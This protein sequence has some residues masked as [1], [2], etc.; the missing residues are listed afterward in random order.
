MKTPPVA[1]L[2]ALVVLAATAGPA[3][4]ETVYITN[5]LRVGLHEERALDSAI[6]KLVP[7]GTA[8]EVIK[9]DNSLSFVRDPDGTTGWV[10]NSYLNALPPARPGSAQE[11]EKRAAVLEQR[12]AEASQRVQELEA[13]A[14]APQTAGADGQQVENL[15]KELAATGQQLKAERLKAG[16]LQVQ[17]AEMR[18]RVGLSSDNASL[19]EQIDRLESENKRLEVALAGTAGGDGASPADAG[20]ATGNG[21][22]VRIGIGRLAAYVAI[23]LIVGFGGGVYL[24]DYLNRRRHGG[25]RI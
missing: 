13:Q 2:L 10:D 20:A 18:K 3:T 25:F 4:A 16:E 23:F 22:T 9:K 17:V 1:P 24:L 21:A 5:E 19:Y 11:I 8:L 15:R 6:L 14:G 12:L 7:S